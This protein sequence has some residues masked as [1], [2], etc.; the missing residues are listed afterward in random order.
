M[1]TNQNK[2]WHVTRAIAKRWHRKAGDA[3]VKRHRDM[4]A[5]RAAWQADVE[6]WFA[7]QLR[8][9]TLPGMAI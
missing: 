8:E 1:R 9:P 6:A 3:A 7:A 5:G 2:P 4:M